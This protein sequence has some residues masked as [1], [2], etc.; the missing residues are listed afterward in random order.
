MKDSIIRG[1]NREALWAYNTGEMEFMAY[2][3]KFFLEEVEDGCC[4]VITTDDMDAGIRIEN[5]VVY[6]G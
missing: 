2:G 1:I 6:C 4:R 3:V 5:G